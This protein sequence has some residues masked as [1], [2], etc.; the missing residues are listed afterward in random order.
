MILIIN[1]SV[2]NNFASTKIKLE[3]GSLLAPYPCSPATWNDCEG[4]WG[5]A[6]THRRWRK[7][8]TGGNCASV[9]RTVDQ[10]AVRKLIQQRTRYCDNNSY[11]VGKEG[12]LCNTLMTRLPP[13][14]PLEVVRLSHLPLS[15]PA[16]R[17]I[18]WNFGYTALTV[19]VHYHPRV[20]VARVYCSDPVQ[21]EGQKRYC[22]II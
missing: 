1:S 5:S 15:I 13:W 8:K 4:V 7:C 19:S 22:N 20:S 11:L 16:A 18:H 12:V 3:V 6:A 17:R 14:Y 10:D 2:A 9:H 21:S